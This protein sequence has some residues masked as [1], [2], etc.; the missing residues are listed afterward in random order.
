MHF[1]LD[2]PPQPRAAG[3]ARQFV[4]RHIRECVPRE[5]ADTAVLLTSELVTN[6]LVH[7]RTP[8]RLHLDLTGD[9][10][11]IGVADETSRVPTQRESHPA[12]L[13]GRGMTLVTALATEWGVEPNP[14]GKTVWFELLS[15]G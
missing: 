3:V 10:V 13:T 7:A 1:S 4:E 14:P 2:L 15:H 9:T 12:R 6:V 5:T 8:M 11:R